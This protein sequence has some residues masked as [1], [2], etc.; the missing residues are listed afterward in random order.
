MLGVHYGDCISVSGGG[1]TPAGDAVLCCTGLLSNGKL[2]T[3][4]FVAAA[5]TAQQ[6]VEA[7]PD[8]TAPRWLVRDRDA[9]YGDLFRARAPQ[10]RLVEQQSDSDRQPAAQQVT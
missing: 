3:L 4:W 8:D 6:I 9:I 7:F 1:R 5:W 10:V 2:E